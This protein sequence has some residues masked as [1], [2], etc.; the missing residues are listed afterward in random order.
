MP[1]IHGS[2]FLR[3]E[4]HVPGRA[5]AA[6]R[7]VKTRKYLKNYTK[8]RETQSR[9][10]CGRRDHHYRDGRALRSPQAAQPKLSGIMPV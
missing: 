1:N 8:A 9:W 4:A 3:A 5:T 2:S 10:F 6:A 7:P